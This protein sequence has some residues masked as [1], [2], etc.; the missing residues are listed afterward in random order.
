MT[1][2]TYPKLRC[3]RQYLWGLKQISKGK[4]RICG[5]PVSSTNKHLCP[6]HRDMKNE[7]RNAERLKV[8]GRRF[9][10]VKRA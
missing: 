4:C 7:K 3:S 5:K 2:P 10:K 8:N 9:R 6:T 1:K